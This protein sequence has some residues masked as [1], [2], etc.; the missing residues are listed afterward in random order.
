MSRYLQ[1][2]KVLLGLTG[3]IA[4]YKSAELVRQLVREGAQVHVLMSEA[5]QRFITPLT[6]QSLTGN[7]VATDLF[8][9]SHEL[10]IGHIRLADMAHAYL[11]APATADVIAKLAHGLADDIVTTVALATRAPVL[12]APS[13][14]VNMFEHPLLQRNLD[15]L[16]SSGY[17]LI[18]PG[19]GELACGWQ[20]KGRLAEPTVL[21][22]EVE[23]ALA[24]QDFAG[25]RVLVTA[26]PTREFLDP[27]RFLTNRSSGK[28]GFELA[29]A[30]WR[31]GAQVVLIA[32]PVSLPTPHG[33]ERYDVVSAEDMHRAVAREFQK[34]T[35]L[36]M[37][38]AVADYRPAERHPTKLKKQS[39]GWSIAVEPTVDILSRVAAHKEQRFVVGFAAETA[40]LEEEGRRKLL[41]KG[42]DLVVAN[43]VSRA[44]AGMEADVNAAILLDRFGGRLELPLMSKA[45]LADAILDRV[46]ELRRHAAV[47]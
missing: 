11:I 32:G 23:R 5:A 33:V 24:P 46:A 35:M 43:D 40:D 10:H 41:H 22:A 45:D 42:L 39:V 44:D 38:A 29:K 28:M 31:R 3:G 47:N 30:A 19:E 13:M 1:G 25:E 2:K 34:A 9:L 21:L 8:D 14:N 27:V 37:C 12:V 16:R 36:F 17:R 6:M 20:G 4:C 7:Q 15:L 26:G 18:P